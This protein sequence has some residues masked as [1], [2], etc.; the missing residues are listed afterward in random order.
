MATDL[1]QVIVEHDGQLCHLAIPADR[2]ALVLRLI[3]GCLDSGILSLVKLP[4]DF[5]KVPLSEALK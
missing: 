1:V 5:K 4:E 2:K 3:A